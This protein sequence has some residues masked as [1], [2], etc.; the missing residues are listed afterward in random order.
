[1]VSTP[2]ETPQNTLRDSTP[3]AAKI[4]L[5][6]ASISLDSLELTL[7]QTVWAVRL[8][9]LTVSAAYENVPVGCPVLRLVDIALS[10]D[11]LTSCFADDWLT[12]RLHASGDRRPTRSRESHIWISQHWSWDDQRRGG[13][14][15]RRNSDVTHR[16]SQ[17][18]ALAARP[19]RGRPQGRRDGCH[20]PA[21][22]GAEQRTTSRGTTT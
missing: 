6:L 18:T 16:Y 5:L 17:F 1:M 2:R 12:G 19:A 8:L 11:M 4:G 22:E 7:W 3:N 21:A 14:R 20:G 15:S 13:W 10:W 9:V